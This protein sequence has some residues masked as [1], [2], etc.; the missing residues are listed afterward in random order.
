MDRF[1][2][3]QNMEHYM[4]LLKITAD[5]AKRGAMEKLLLEEEAKLGRAEE[6]RERM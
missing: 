1:V 6:D 3:R 2:A 4:E 5:P